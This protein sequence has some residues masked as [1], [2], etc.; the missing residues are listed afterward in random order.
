MTAQ[1]SRSG[2]AS[3]DKSG[4]TDSSLDHMGVK[5]LRSAVLRGRMNDTQ[6]WIQLEF[7]G[8][9]AKGQSL[10]DGF[11]RRFLEAP[12]LEESSQVRKT[13]CPFNSIRLG[14]R[15]KLLSEFCSLQISCLIFEVDADPM[16]R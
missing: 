1:S 2:P 11:Q 5:L 16:C 13:A 9:E 14:Y 7:E 3:N 4:A 10:P 12:E 15:K 8:V 6:N